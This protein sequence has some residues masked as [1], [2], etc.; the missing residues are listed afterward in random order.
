M[1]RALADFFAKQEYMLAYAVV[2]AS[3]GAVAFVVHRY[4][5]PHTELIH[6]IED[7]WRIEDAV[8]LLQTIT[9]TE[10]STEGVV[11][12]I[13]ATIHAHGIQEDT[14]SRLSALHRRYGDDAG[15]RG[16]AINML[17]ST[18]LDSIARGAVILG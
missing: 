12:R 17:W 5:R 4:R 16:Y 3:V 15:C 7:I 10:Q 6:L 2:G 14:V 9:A 1:H 8:R 18:V 13:A 11:E